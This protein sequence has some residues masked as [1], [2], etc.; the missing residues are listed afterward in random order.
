[1]DILEELSEWRS[2]PG[3]KS[4]PVRINN[5][6]MDK[7]LNSAIDEIARLRTIC[8]DVIETTQ[9]DTRLM[10]GEL[11]SALE[12]VQEIYDRASDYYPSHPEKPA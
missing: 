12:V 6:A 1:M 2:A 4:G 10:N 5:R 9:T 11:N 7:L 8:Q 3:S